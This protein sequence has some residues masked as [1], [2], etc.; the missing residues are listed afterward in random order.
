MTILI[1][2]RAS[3]AGTN[4]KVL[5]LEAGKPALYGTYRELMGEER[6]RVFVESQEREGAIAG[7]KGG[8]E[9]TA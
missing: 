5:Y 4:D 9:V 3:A 2:Q 8:E 7:A 6:F 1:S